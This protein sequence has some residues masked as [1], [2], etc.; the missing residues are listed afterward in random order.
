MAE[1]IINT[2][3][4]GL[5][6]DSTFILQPDGTYRN[7]KNGMLISHDGNHYVIELSKGNK[8]I[9][10]LPSRYHSNEDNYTDK[11]RVP[12]PI[13][14]ISFIDKLVVF[15][16]NNEGTNGGYGEL[17]V[18]NFTKV[19][20]DF[21]SS[22]VP[23]YH[24]PSL[25]FTKYHKIEGFAFREND[26]IERVYWTDNFNEPRVFD[27]AN[28]IFT[29]YIASGD[30]VD[31]KQ[32]M[33]LQGVIDY[34]GD[35]YGPSDDSSSATEAAP[36]VNSNIF[37]ANAT[38]TY[39][40]IDGSPLVIEYYP[41]SLLDWT[42]DRLLGNINFQEYGTGTKYCG[43][44]IYFY[45]L[46]SSVDGIQ[47]SWS[48]ASNPIQ[49]L[50][51]NTS[52]AVIAQSNN[53]H[54]IAGAGTTTTLVNSTKSVKVRITN[55]D[56][57][58]DTIELCC[59]EF[60]QE[61]E[62][63]YS[64][65]IVVKTAITD[66]E[67][68]LEDTGSSNLGTVTINDLTLFPA[69]ILKVKTIAT[70]KNYNAIA[71]ITE[72]EEFS[73]DVSG[74]TVSSFEYPLI[75]HGDLDVCTNNFTYDP[76][77]PVL[78]TNP[79]AT[80]ILPYS[81]YLVSLAPDASNRV[82]YPVASGDFYYTGDVFVGVAGSTTATFTGTA[83]ARPCATRNRYT[84]IN[85]S[86]FSGD[87]VEDAIEIKTGFWD[88]KDPLVA[89]HCKGYWSDDKYR[90]GILFFDLKG[91]PFY[92][93]HLTDFT[94]PNAY[95]KGGL[96]KSAAY[97]VGGNNEMYYLN[98]SGLTISNL[99]I[100][101]E[102]VDQVSGFS[103]V[104]AERDV[105][106]VTQG[107]VM[108][109]VQGVGPLRPT[110]ALNLQQSYGVDERP[111]LVYI[112]PDHLDNSPMKKTFGAAGDSFEE[113]SWI[114]PYDYTGGGIFIK[115]DGLNE[116]SVS[117]LFL[118]GAVDAASP[119]KVEIDVLDGDYFRSFNENESALVDSGAYTFVN[120]IYTD[121]GL[122]PPIDLTCSVGGTTNMTNWGAAGSRKLL[123]K[124][125]SMFLHYNSIFNYNDY[126]NIVA[127]ILMNYVKN[128]DPINQYGGTSANAIASTLYMSTGHFQPITPQVIADNNDTNNP[129]SYTKLTFNDIEVFGGDCFVN[130]IDSNY[131]V[132]DSGK[133]G[134]DFSYTLYFVCENNS[135]YA[136]RRGKTPSRIGTYPGYPSG[137]VFNDGSG[138]IR[139][140]DYQYNEAY[141]T[142]G[143][144][145]KYPALP[146][147]YRFTGKFEYRTR[148]AGPKFPGELINSFRTF[149]V[150]DYR[151]LDG[152][153][154]E[155][156]NLKVRDSKLFFWQNHG[157]GYLPILERQLVG[158]ATLGGATAL[159]VGGVIDRF[160]D[161]DTY[162]GNQHQHGLT[163]TEFGFIWFDMRRRALCIMQTGGQIQEISLAKGLQVFF[164][165]EFN[166][167]D[168]FL[169]EGIYNTNNS[170]IPEIPL[171]GYGIVGTYDPRFKMS[172]LTFKYTKDTLIDEEDELVT[173]EAKDFTIGYC[174]VLNAIIGFYDFTPAIWHNHNDLV[175][176]ANDS[177]NRKY[178]GANMPDTTFSVGDTIRVKDNVN[179]VDEG[180][181]VC[182][183]E[184]NIPAYPPVE[185]KDPLTV[186]SIYW[187]KINEQSEI[188]L[189]TFNTQ[190]LKFYGKVY[191]HELEIII[192][193]K[194]D[195]PFTP[196]NIQVKAVGS[197]FTDVYFDNEDQSSKDVNISATSRNYRW[198]DKAWFSNVPLDFKKGRLTDYYTKIKFVY[199]GYVSDPTVSKNV[200]KV[201]QWI[202]TWFMNKK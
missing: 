115:S 8:V 164:N 36:Y 157:V 162:F 168:I 60:T 136:L 186:D 19:G 77:G 173:V 43:E 197:N 5:H 12:M 41:I 114:D 170:S 11:D 149:P 102:I 123:F 20:D 81:R 83:Q 134:T 163:E 138:N 174:H 35:Y 187:V 148:W 190:Y 189:Q 15:M 61:S 118:S 151:D 66:D 180:E 117:K 96:V 34:N 171:L 45:R 132:F 107:L 165:N 16:T 71:N 131:G 14:F 140:E 52:T 18:V 55:I 199:K 142:E 2:F 73:L 101:K 85:S 200:N 184:V 92:V 56:T 90:I 110:G 128:I 176:S 183:K 195:E 27:I 158:G 167:G 126:T 169:S 30:L 38:T 153:R 84:K 111:I 24:H 196:Q 39:T 64:I 32:Y 139:L 26:A 159:G 97:V 109:T 161:I 10:N 193:P 17:G 188:Y 68:T 181:Y 63:P 116:T 95:S 21:T 91:N 129:S 125:K 28:P 44:S 25:M 54:N 58:F 53:Y 166:E 143:T 135:N 192:N 104:R 78:S 147:N 178:Y 46:S 160:D 122:G 47:T 100:P 48:Y 194:V 74:V 9:L 150:N 112:C 201:T 79:V 80:S 141:N 144:F 62:I 133:S 172:Y 93:K 120:E 70:N 50:A 59:A 137:I 33:I 87:R 179:I 82:E 69:S 4:K 155:I 37:T 13:G 88:Y 191:N 51:L 31:G 198:I 23:Y 6:Q 202:K 121:S 119:R 177:K 75:A 127:K 113:V 89:S 98:P 57:V 106:I 156:N 29:N 154:G 76:H 175:L 65:K 108:Q 67:M 7:M 86:A 185:A 72:R 42:P 145:I 130:I 1:S 22:Y 3:E 103:I 99:E 124:P 94:F 152:Q 182:I 40:V 49:I 146:A 105:R